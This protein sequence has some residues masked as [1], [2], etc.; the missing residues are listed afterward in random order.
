MITLQPTTRYVVLDQ[1]CWT[2]IVSVPVDTKSGFK[3]TCRIIYSGDDRI[4]P[5]ADALFQAERLL[6]TVI[7]R[8]WISDNI[9]PRHCGVDQMSRGQF[10]EF[11][12]SVTLP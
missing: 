12:T 7:E 5:A 8:F 3:P 1:D 6:F 11:V 10:I 2:T 9:D 4:G